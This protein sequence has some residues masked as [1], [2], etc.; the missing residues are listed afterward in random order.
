MAAILVYVSA[1]EGRMSAFGLKQLASLRA[2]SEMTRDPSFLLVPQN[3]QHT[4]IC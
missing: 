3:I 2:F 4:N 1:A